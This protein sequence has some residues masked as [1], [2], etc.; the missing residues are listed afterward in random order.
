MYTNRTYVFYSPT[1]LWKVEVRVSVFVVSPVFI[2]TFIYD[3]VSRNHGNFYI[4]LLA[5]VQGLYVVIHSE[6][7][8]TGGVVVEG[9]GTASGVGRRGQEG[10]EDTGEGRFRRMWE[11]AA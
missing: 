3:L 10:E 5:L 11:R 6:V 9:N 8:G 1:R 2:N 4:K 7:S